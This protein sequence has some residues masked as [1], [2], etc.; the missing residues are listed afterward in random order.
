MNLKKQLVLC[1][2]FVTECPAGTTPYYTGPCPNDKVC[3]SNPIQNSWNATRYWNDTLP[4][5]NW[6]PSNYTTNY[7]MGG[8]QALFLF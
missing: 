5:Y 2:M 1:P 3:Q 8:L 4:S 6:A 7:T